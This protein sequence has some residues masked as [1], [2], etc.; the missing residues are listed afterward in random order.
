LKEIHVV[1]A[2]IVDGDR[3]LATRRS[4][5]MPLPL[6]WEFP[7]GKVEP[8]EEPRAALARE[9]AEELGLDIAVGEHLATGYAE[10]SVRRVRLEVYLATRRA[11]TLELREHDRAGWFAE[12][13]L[14]ALQ[15]AQADLPAVAALGSYLR[16]R[17]E[18]DLIEPTTTPGE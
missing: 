6:Q 12:S 8:G 16:R 9:V 10:D 7:G 17:T 1:G 14:G 5:A 4:A 18:G 3:C 2:A 13:E 11:G 15:W